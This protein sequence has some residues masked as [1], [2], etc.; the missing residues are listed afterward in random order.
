[1]ITA[2]GTGIGEE[3]KIEKLRYHKIIIMTDA[4]VDGSHIQTL[5]MTFFFRQMRQLVEGGHIYLA[6]PPLYKL[7]V[8]KDERY[9][10]TEEDKE[11][12][13]SSLEDR[14]NI[15]LQRYKG[16]GEMNPEQLAETTMIPEK[17]VLKQTYIEDAVLADQVFTMLMGEEVEPRRRFIEENAYRVMDTLDV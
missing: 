11:A 7:K 16:L 8:G 1:M 12:A 2:I 3:F 5:L 13:L 6:Q 9:L 4:D 14:K 10:F 15:Y 17:R